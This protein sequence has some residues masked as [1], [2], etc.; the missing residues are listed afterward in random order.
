MSIDELVDQMMGDPTVKAMG[1]IFRADGSFTDSLSGSDKRDAVRNAI[2]LIVD[3][4]ILSHDWNFAMKTEV[5]SG[6]SVINQPTYTLDEDQDIMALYSVAY[7]GVPLDKKSHAEI[8]DIKKTSTIVAVAFWTLDGVDNQKPIIRLH[9]TPDVAGKVIDYR[10][11]VRVSFDVLP[12]EFTL[13]IKE[14][15]RSQFDARRRVVYL[16]MRGELIGKH[17]TKGKADDR[18]A[19][20][21]PDIS[22]R[23]RGIGRR[24]GW[25][26]GH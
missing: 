20:Q 11:W 26:G 2:P 8:E 17:A 9:K 25:G 22:A 3:D 16:D 1:R 10:Y 15:V 14:G 23:N 12:R 21:D 19:R 13:T 7:N 24:Y 18:P 5:V 6:G 4:V